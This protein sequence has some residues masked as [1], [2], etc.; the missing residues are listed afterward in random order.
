MFA[1]N[2]KCNQA[3]KLDNKIIP[4]EVVVHT[5]ICILCVKSHFLTKST[6][7]RKG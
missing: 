1:K 3:N 5:V 6:G 7:A 4:K 2:Y